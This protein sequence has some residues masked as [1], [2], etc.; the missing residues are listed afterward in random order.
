MTRKVFFMDVLTANSTRRKC[1]HPFLAIW[2][3]SFSV[4]HDTK[5]MTPW[6]RFLMPGCLV[7]AHTTDTFL[8]PGLSIQC[9]D[10]KISRT[11]TPIRSCRS[12]SGSARSN[13]MTR[14]TPW[15]SWILLLRVRCAPDQGMCKAILMTRRSGFQYFVSDPVFGGPVSTTWTWVL[16]TQNRKCG[17]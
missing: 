10:K 16:M 3:R 4:F 7:F 11:W 14:N 13:F 17:S 8:G 15:L 6:C 2:A 1:I 12:I 9:H 5:T